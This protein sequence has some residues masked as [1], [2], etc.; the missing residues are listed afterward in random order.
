MPQVCGELRQF[1]PNIKAGA[2]PLDE[3]PCGETVT[4]ILKPG[5]PGRCAGFQLPVVLQL[6]RRSWRMCGVRRNPVSV[7]RA[8]KSETLHSSDANRVCAAAWH[9]SPEPRVLS[10][11]A[12]RNGI[13]RICSVEWT[14]SRCRD[15]HRNCLRPELLLGGGL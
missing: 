13:F 1:T 3:L 12:G 10:P 14:R 15:Q 5:P 4:K 7:G 8:R 9:T 6:R 11:P 2:I